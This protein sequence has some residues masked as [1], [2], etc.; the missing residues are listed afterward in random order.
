MTKMIE[1]GILFTFLTEKQKEPFKELVKP[2]YE[3]MEEIVGKA[4]L[5]AYLSAVDAAR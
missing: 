2:S 1:S 3:I 5:E 4:D